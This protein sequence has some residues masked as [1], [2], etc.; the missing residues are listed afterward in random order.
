[1]T[2]KD[3]YNKEVVLKM[4]KQFNL[5]NSLE[6]PR[7][8]KVVVNAGIGKFLKET[9]SVSEIMEA[10]TKITGQKPLM[11]K[12][13]KSIAGFK[14]REGLEVG[15]KVTLR[16]NRMWNFIEKLV[17]T[18]LPRVKDFRGL[19]E[20]SI[21]G[22]GNLNIGIKE[23]LIFPE[24]SPEQTKYIFSLEVTAVTN[25]KDRK[26]GLTLFKLLGF[27]IKDDN[28]DNKSNRTIK[29]AGN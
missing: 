18:A 24:I 14:I 3:K 26:K 10:L 9:A 6:V 4:K 7:I 27:P 15:M 20:S 16:G 22:Q 1:M 8:E 29:V 13:R 17:G 19:K 25:A 23:H 21:D 28:E 2:I 11:T 5:A 12:A